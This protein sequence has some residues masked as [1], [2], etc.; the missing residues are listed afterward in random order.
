MIGQARKEDAAS[1]YGYTGALS[2]N[3]QGTS[4]QARPPSEPPSPLN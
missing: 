3:I 2:A 1:V 4:G